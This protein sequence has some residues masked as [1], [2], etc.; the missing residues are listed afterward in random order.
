M[1][2]A[3]TKWSAL[4]G[5]LV[6]FGLSSVAVAEPG[7][8]H[9]NKLCD[10]RAGTSLDIKVTK[11]KRKM[12]HSDVWVTGDRYEANHDGCELTLSYVV[13]TNGVRRLSRGG[14]CSSSHPA[15]YF[16]LACFVAKMDR[17]GLD[18]SSLKSMEWGRMR[19]IR[20]GPTVEGERL[21]ASVAGHKRWDKKKGKLKKWRV[22][23]RGGSKKPFIVDH[24]ERGE[25][26]KELN[27]IFAAYKLL[28]TPSY[29]EMVF[30]IRA[31]KLSNFAALR[32]KKVRKGHK[33]PFDCAVSFKV[34][35][36]EPSK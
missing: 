28:L 15:H 22:P 4:V 26:F 2:T 25:A 10:E 24:L 8:T 3:W 6:G 18:L 32:K 16:M 27:S 34:S 7:P 12:P 36:L 5:L 14:A 9:W 20:E 13:K 33:L 29:A 35:R 21:A 17:D 1:S 31:E 19:S 11:S 30:V 23:K